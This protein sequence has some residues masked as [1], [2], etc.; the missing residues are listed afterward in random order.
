MWDSSSENLW[1]H[2]DMTPQRNNDTLGSRLI[3]NME[4][5]QIWLAQN[6]ITYNQLETS[7]NISSLKG[8]ILCDNRHYS[9]TK[10]SCPW[11]IDSMLYGYG[12]HVVD[13]PNCLTTST[14]IKFFWLPLSAIK[15]NGV[16]FTHI[17]E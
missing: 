12:C 9:V 10:R 15:C 16:P 5:P 4:L 11:K 2:V 7:H 3:D 6:N 13:N 8:W 14:E 1:Y 17:C